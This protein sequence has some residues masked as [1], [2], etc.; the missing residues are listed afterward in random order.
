MKQF[1][2]YKSNGS[3][4]KAGTTIIGLCVR[5]LLPLDDVK[6]HYNA[7]MG[8]CGA[9]LPDTCRGLTL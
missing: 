6:S 4:W 7:L 5:S 1:I 2:V 3:M 8:H 9:I